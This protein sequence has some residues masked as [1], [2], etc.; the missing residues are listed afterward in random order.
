M[1]QYY[2]ANLL[3]SKGIK[4]SYLRIRI[5][6]YMLTMR[7]HPTV[8][9]IYHALSPEIPTLSRTTIYNTVDL[10]LENRL[11]QLI[12]IDEKEIRYDADISTHAHFLCEKCGRILDLP[13]N[14]DWPIFESPDIKIR[15]IQYYLKGLC[16]QC[17]EIS[18]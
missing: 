14:K 3:Q 12:G 16:K 17:D 2:A 11:V 18:N 5:L 9:M 13:I 6:S 15:E 4:P 7:N 1:D 10:F 8:D